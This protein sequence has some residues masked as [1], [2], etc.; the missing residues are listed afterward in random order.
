MHNL[1]S[2]LTQYGTQIALRSKEQFP[3]VQYVKWTEENF[4]YVKYNPRNSFN[5][6]GL[7]LTSYDGGLS[8]IPDLDSL[9]QYNLENNTTIEESE[10]NIPT[11]AYLD[12][13]H[14][15]EFLKPYS[16][17]MYRTHILKLDP[18]GFFPQH[19]D[20]RGSNFNSVR[21]ISPLKNH[22]TFIMDNKVLNWEKGDLYFLDTA[23]VHSLFNTQTKPSYWLVANINL[24]E[25]S[26][27]IITDNFDKR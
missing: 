1:Y 24:N 13:Y 10:F 26:F 11:P 7:S 14:I 16:K 15:Q 2:S 9:H 6:W 23:K 22:C 8:G 4:K 3:S 27:N 19:R 18:G 17:Y 5:R 21:L 12:N 20:F 25:E